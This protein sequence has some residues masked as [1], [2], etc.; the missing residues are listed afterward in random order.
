MSDMHSETGFKL[1]DR[2]VG[3]VFVRM[4][5]NFQDEA[6]EWIPTEFIFI[7]IYDFHFSYLRSGQF[8]T[9]PIITLWGNYSFAHNF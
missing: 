9:R 5:S 3:T 6:L 2:A 7:Y 4:F 1:E 8:L